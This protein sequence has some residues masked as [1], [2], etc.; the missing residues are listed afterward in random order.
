VDRRRWRRT[1]AKAGRVQAAK[2][3]CPF[4]LAR[5]GHVEESRADFLLQLGQLFVRRRN[6]ALALIIAD[7]GPRMLFELVPINHRVADPIS[8]RRTLTER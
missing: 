7:A 4:V 3:E 1:Q 2:Q 5:P 8:E 6:W